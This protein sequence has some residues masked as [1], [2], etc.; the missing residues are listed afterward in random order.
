MLANAAQNSSVPLAMVAM[1]APDSR[2]I[3]AKIP[4]VVSGQKHVEV[5][6]S[7]L[8]YEGVMVMVISM[9]VRMRGQM[10]GSL[11]RSS[12][13][14]LENPLVK[15]LL[16]SLVLSTRLLRHVMEP[17]VAKTLQIMVLLTRFYRHAME[18]H[19]VKELGRREDTLNSLP[20]VATLTVLV[21]S[22]IH[23]WLL[24]FWFKFNISSHH[25]SLSFSSFY[26]RLSRR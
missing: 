15:T 13:L 4:L 6:T 10:E 2:D 8:Y 5:P 25:M 9:R 14:A 19:L 22:E 17:L 16:E 23:V 12:T 1:H 21:V 18:Y 7:P 24:L 26:S 3:S 11:E 20:I